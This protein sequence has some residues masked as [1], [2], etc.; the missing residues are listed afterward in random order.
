MLA[1][2]EKW[3][4]LERWLFSYT[5]PPFEEDYET[6]AEQ[7]EENLADLHRAEG[8]EVAWEVEDLVCTPD[9]IREV[10]EARL[11]WLERQAA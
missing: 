3:E 11:V 10:V 2:G 7:Y 5:E 6:L 4:T 9:E 8:D 1:R